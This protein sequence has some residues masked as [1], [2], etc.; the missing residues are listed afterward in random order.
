MKDSNPLEYAR[1]LEIPTCTCQVTVKKS[2]KRKKK[3]LDGDELKQQVMDSVNARLAAAPITVAEEV[4]EELEKREETQVEGEQIQMELPA[5]DLAEGE[6]NQEDAAQ[7]LDEEIPFESDFSTVTVT[8]KSKKGLFGFFHRK[9]QKAEKSNVVMS[10]VLASAALVAVIFLTNVF[11]PSSAINRIIR[12][13]FAPSS[14]QTADVRDYAEFTAATPY[15]AGDMQ[16]DG[17]IMTFEGTGTLYAP[18]DGIVTRIVEDAGKKTLEI[19][20]SKKFR[21]VLSGIDFAYC[22]VGDS[23]YGAL[24]VGYV[25]GG[26]VSVAMYNDGVLL[27]N[28]VLDGGAVVWQS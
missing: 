22:D 7:T 4:V 11:M 25:N 14:V 19:E 24:P 16:L 26:T 18:C 17:G 27:Q 13:V 1:M 28:Y 5:E 6:K 15:R 3:P 8:E 12:T 21:T 20:H 23:V 2:K 9:K 10:M